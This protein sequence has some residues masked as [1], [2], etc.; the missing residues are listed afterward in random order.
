MFGRGFFENNAER[1]G[2][3]YIRNP[4]WFGFNVWICFECAASSEHAK[5]IMDVWDQRWTLLTDHEQRAIIADLRKNDLFSFH[6]LVRGE[7]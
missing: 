1:Y 3:A 7:A 5:R 6:R 2:M 4:D